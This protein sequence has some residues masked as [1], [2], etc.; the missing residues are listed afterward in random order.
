[1][2]HS[3]LCE[4]R[5]KRVFTIIEIGTTGHYASRAYDYLYAFLIIL[6]LTVSIMYTF[7]RLELLCGQL[8]LSTE[9][10]TVAFFAFDYALRL[11]TAKFLYPGVSEPQAIRKYMKSFS[12]IVDISL[13]CPIIYPFSSPPPSFLQALWI[14]TPA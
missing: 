5:R 1:M 4:K 11:W 12:G 6:N 2:E 10:V 3:S 9:K 7:D 13:S 14:T 8:L